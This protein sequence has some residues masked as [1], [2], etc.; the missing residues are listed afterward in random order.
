ML[1][2]FLNYEGEGKLT[3]VRIYGND[4]SKEM[5]IEKTYIGPRM[6]KETISLDD[7]YWAFAKELI[8]TM[9]EIKRRGGRKDLLDDL[10][11]IYYSISSS[12]KPP[13]RSHISNLERE[14]KEIK[15]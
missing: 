12:S 6:I 9:I 11:K 3:V 13:K 15:E 14:N 7:D 4:V 8:V 2:T 10:E 5:T 1:L